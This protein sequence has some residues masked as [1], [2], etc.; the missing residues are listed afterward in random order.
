ML[1]NRVWGIAIVITLNLDLQTKI[2][3][4]RELHK[5]GIVVVVQRTNAG[6]VRQQYDEITP[7]ADEFGEAVAHTAPSGR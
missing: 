1:M 6:V 5:R 4:P 7:L 3:S 2:I